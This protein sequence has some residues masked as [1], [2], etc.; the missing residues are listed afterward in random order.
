MTGGTPILGNLQVYILYTILWSHHPKQNSQ[1]VMNGDWNVQKTCPL[2]EK[3]SLCLGG[4]LRE[5][6]SKTVLEFFLAG[7]VFGVRLTA[8]RCGALTPPLHYRVSS[9]GG[10]VSTGL[11]WESS[12][13]YFSRCFWSSKIRFWKSRA[14]WP[15]Q[16]L[17]KNLARWPTGLSI[18]R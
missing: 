5:A 6:G 8:R 7:E 18:L 13:P 9:L 4:T 1:Q 15:L 14:S 17:C 2:I 16:K 10:L 12:I 3:T 11:T